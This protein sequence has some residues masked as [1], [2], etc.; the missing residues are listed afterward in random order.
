MKKYKVI[1]RT[2]L[3]FR[4]PFYTLLLIWLALDRFSVPDWVWGS[5]GLFAVLVVSVWVLS[6]WREESTDIFKDK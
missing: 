1:D 2:N 6:F 4:Q 3:P 5:F